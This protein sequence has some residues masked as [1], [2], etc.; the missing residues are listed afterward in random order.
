MG[1]LTGVWRYLFDIW[2]SF[3]LL[4]PP[5]LIWTIAI[6]S[7]LGYVFGIFSKVIDMG[8]QFYYNRKTPPIRTASLP[9]LGTCAFAAD[10]RSFSPFR[11][12]NA[13]AERQEQ[14]DRNVKLSRIQQQRRLE[15]LARLEAER[16]KE[17]ERIRFITKNS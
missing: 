3:I 12:H 6:L 13:A 2:D 7:F 14:F 1:L 4:F 5:W 15:E 9:A 17:E 10:N 16:R 8:Y 11:S